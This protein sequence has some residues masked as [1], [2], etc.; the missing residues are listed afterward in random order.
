MTPAILKALAGLAARWVLMVT[1]RAMECDCAAARF[2]TNRLDLLNEVD[3]RIL[4][5]RKTS[6]D[7]SR[8]PAKAR[9][10]NP[11]KPCRAAPRWKILS[12]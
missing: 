8:A 3:Q 9:L 7:F 1:I 12:V 2:C 10:P 11:R 6:G 4:I 5:H